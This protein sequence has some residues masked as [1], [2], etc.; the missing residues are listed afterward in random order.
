M[1]RLSVTLFALLPLWVAAISQPVLASDDDDDDRT[2][3]RYV[4]AHNPE[5][6]AIGF[7]EFR[8]D[9]RK[10]R[11]HAN[12][13]GAAE[14]GFVTAWKF[15]NGAL[16]GHLD[17]TMATKGGDALLSG[18]IRISKRRSSDVRLVF[19]RH[20]WTI[21]DVETND[22]LTSELTTPSGEGGGTDLGSCETSFASGRHR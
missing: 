10:V 21:M 7:C 19:R 1:F 8:R 11:A 20:N 14:N 6:Y 5:G 12:V 22:E 18:K 17:G 15:V 13:T 4:L 3:H 16:I 9:G 2:E